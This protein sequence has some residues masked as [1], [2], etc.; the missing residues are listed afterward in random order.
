MLYHLRYPLL[1]LDIVARKVKRRMIFQTLTM[2]GDE[3]YPAPADLPIDGRE[4]MLEPGWPKMAFIEHRLA[5]DPTNWWAPDHACVEAMLRS[6]GLAVRERPG[7]E[8]Y[9]CE[10]APPREETAWIED[11]LRA[12]TGR[13]VPRG[14]GG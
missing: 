4:A 11:E 5:N 10:P 6:A 3:V 14:G 9:V 12:A 13:P 2:P 8:I 1:G 7:H